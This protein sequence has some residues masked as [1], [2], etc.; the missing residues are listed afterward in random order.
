MF[1]NIIIAT[2]RTVVPVAVASVVLWAATTFDFAVPD[3]LVTGWSEALIVG[4]TTGYYVLVSFL[5]RAVN[6]AFGWLL[7]SASAPAYDRG[8]DQES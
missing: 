7:G 3:D 4:I 1:R 8:D 2:I 6:P 5:E